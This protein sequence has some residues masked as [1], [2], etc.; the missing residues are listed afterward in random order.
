MCILSR[1][2]WVAAW[3]WW[4]AVGWEGWEGWEGCWGGG[5]DDGW[6]DGDWEGTDGGWESAAAKAVMAR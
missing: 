1:A 5:W 4:C 2:S 6:G 3:A